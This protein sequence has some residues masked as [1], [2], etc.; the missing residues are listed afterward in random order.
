MKA[1]KYIIVALIALLITSFVSLGVF[2]EKVDFEYKITATDSD[3]YEV[4][5]LR[6]LTAGSV[7]NIEIELKRGDVDESFYLV[8]GIE[9]RLFD[10][11]QFF[12]LFQSVAR[13][14]RFAADESHNKLDS[15][16]FQ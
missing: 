5:D 2:A 15:S 16:H 13:N 7:L 9:L 3:G 8:S 6:S 12:A 10:F 1:A 11:G 14:T 4:T